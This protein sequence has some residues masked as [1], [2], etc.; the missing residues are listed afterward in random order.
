MLATASMLSVFE[1]TPL[2]RFYAKCCCVKCLV[3]SVVAP[4][5]YLQFRLKI[6]V[7]DHSSLFWLDDFMQLEMLN[8][9]VRF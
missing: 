9:A 6:T 1:I 7:R 2:Q 8:N 3:Q 4:R 5:A